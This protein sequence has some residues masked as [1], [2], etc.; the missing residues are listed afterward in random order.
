MADLCEL[1]EQAR[2][3][4]GRAGGLA[5]EGGLHELWERIEHQMGVESL[6]GGRR[7]SDVERI[8]LSHLVAAADAQAV[9]AFEI[10]EVLRTF[11]CERRIELHPEVQP[12]AES[13]S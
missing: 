9:Q 3:W 1:A 2:D 7:F 5:G 10:A 4:L 6:A 13:E 12:P 8:L 11:Y